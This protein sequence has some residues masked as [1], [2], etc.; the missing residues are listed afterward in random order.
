MVLEVGVN[1]FDPIVDVT[2]NGAKSK[3]MHEI[4]EAGA[5]RIW[6]VLMHSVWFERLKMFMNNND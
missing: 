5:D 3:I 2:Q 4:Q 1:G 6:Y